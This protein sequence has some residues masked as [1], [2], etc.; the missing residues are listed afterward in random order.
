MR[1][2]Y[3]GLLM[4][5]VLTTGVAAWAQDSKPALPLIPSTPAKEIEDKKAEEKK[6]AKKLTEQEEA[7]LEYKKY[8]E[9]QQKALQEMAKLASHKQSGEVKVIGSDKTSKLQTLT[10]TADNRVLALVAPPRGYGAPVKGATAEVQ[11]FDAEGK[12]LD[13][14][15]VSFHAH[16]INA[17]ADGTVYVAGDGKVARFDKDG[18]A[19]GEAME[20]PHITEMF[21]DKDSLRKKAEE[22]LKAQKAQREETMKAARK[23][24]EAT[25]KKVEEIKE[26]ERTKAQTRQLQQAKDILKAYDQMEKQ[27][28][29]QT[30]ESVIQ[31]MTGRVRIINGIAVSEKDVFITCGESAGYGYA[32]WRFDRDLKNPKQI[33]KGLGGCCGQM[34][35]QV[36][37]SDVVMAENTKH[38]FAKYD[39]N[40]EKLGS[41]GKRGT[42]AD[43]ACFGGCCNPMNTRAAG[44]SG[45]I[46]T[47]ESEGVVKRFSAT[48][49][50][51]G[52]AA[53]VKIEG[54]CKNVAIGVSTDGDKIVFCDQPGSK[55]FILTKKPEG[56]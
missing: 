3:R 33:L 15:K 36:S 46:Y 50:F 5:A 34:D 30:V 41:F 23:Q 6:P 10:L 56:K 51:I 22:T 14:W 53:T 31:S 48:G 9:A 32:V 26:E 47:A 17:A 54:G 39:R 19:I 1:S 55:F 44:G 38:Q 16:S 2:I 24:F 18:K 37:G 13:T 52:V 11:V 20:L 42:D 8:Q 40:G 7:E 4:S 12:K 45:D 21:K 29:T 43:P 25:I 49:A 27:E 35:V 28:G